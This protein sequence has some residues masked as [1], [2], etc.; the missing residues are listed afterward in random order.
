MKLR[1][2]SHPYPLESFFAAEFHLCTNFLNPQCRY[3]T[4]LIISSNMWQFERQSQLNDW[5]AN[6]TNARLFEAGSKRFIE[7]QYQMTTFPLVTNHIL[8]RPV[9]HNNRFCEDDF[10]QGFHEFY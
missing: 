5:E 10:C 4:S 8:L 9:G 3:L 7:L 2:L 1:E 6:I